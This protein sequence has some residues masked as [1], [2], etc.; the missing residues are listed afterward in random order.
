[1]VLNDHWVFAYLIYTKIVYNINWQDA[2]KKKNIHEHFEQNAGAVPQW[3]KNAGKSP[4]MSRIS[5]KSMGSRQRE[6]PLILSAQG[7]ESEVSRLKGRLF[8]EMVF[9]KEILYYRLSE[10]MSP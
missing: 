9:R 8:Q 6:K 3:G 2:R 10:R 7:T 5:Q 1:M 4:E